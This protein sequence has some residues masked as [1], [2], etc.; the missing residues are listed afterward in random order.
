MNQWMIFHE[1]KYHCDHPITIYANHDIYRR[2][3]RLK[4]HDYGGGCGSFEKL[5]KRSFRVMD[6]NETN[7]PCFLN[8]P[9]RHHDPRKLT[10]G[11]HQT[12]QR[13]EVVMMAKAR[14]EVE[15]KDV[16]V[17]PMKKRITRKKI[18]EK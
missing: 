6:Y 12:H 7:L 5:M 8:M 14:E 15:A 10:R 18:K 16:A 13:I 17:V 1:I 4:K 2:I 3:W 9:S 11:F